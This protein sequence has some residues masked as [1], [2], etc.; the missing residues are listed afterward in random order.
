VTEKRCEMNAG[1]LIFLLLIVGGPLA[2]F[3]MHRGGHA[4]GGTAGGGGGGCCGGGGGHNHGG[5][6]E[7]EQTPNQS[8]GTET[9]PL[10]GPPGSGVDAPIPVAA[11]HHRHGG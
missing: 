1:N 6:H 11:G 10:L 9:K 8:D 4:H 3:S 5:G 2:M 7:E